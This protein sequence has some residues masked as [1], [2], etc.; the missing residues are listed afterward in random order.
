MGWQKFWWLNA[1][2][3][4]FTFL[5]NLFLFP[6]T[7]S[8]RVHPIDLG[9]QSSDISDQAS[10]NSETPSKTPKNDA[11]ADTVEMASSFPKLASLETAQKDPFLGKGAPSKTQ[12]RLHQ[13]ADSHYNMTDEILNPWKFFALLI[14]AFAGFV[15]LWSASVFLTINLTQPQNFAPPPYNYDGL[16]IGFFN[17]ALLIGSFMGLFTAGPLSDWMSVRL[18]RRNKGIR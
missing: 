15:I 12:F 6:E 9:N 1:G 7:K 18:T 14:V 10:K 5:S 16:S 11:Q 17:F 4:S 2:L 3:F 8:H 13:S